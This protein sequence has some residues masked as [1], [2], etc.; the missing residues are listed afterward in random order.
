MLRKLVC[1]SLM[2]LYLVPG[3][4]LKE[5][6]KLPV[7]LQ[8]FQVHKSWNQDTTFLGFLEHHYATHP[9]GNPDQ[10]LDN[11][12]PF[13]GHHELT[14]TVLVFSLPIPI[15]HFQFKTGFSQFLQRPVYFYKNV[16]PS[17]HLLTSIWQ[18]PQATSV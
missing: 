16:F 4:A 13:K 1:I 10:D 11:Q 7:L 2:V 15:L 6:T 18:P 12:L 8:H 17:T 9:D 5:L 3:S 14:S